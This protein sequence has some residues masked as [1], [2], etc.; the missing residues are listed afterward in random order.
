M[1]KIVFQIL[2]FHNTSVRTMPKNVDFS[3]Y[4]LYGGGNGEKGGGMCRHL[5]TQI[6]IFIVIHCVLYNILLN[7]L[8]SPPRL[9]HLSRD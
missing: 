6:K 3:S 7:T 1:S 4:D 5:I 9:P 2:I 8:S